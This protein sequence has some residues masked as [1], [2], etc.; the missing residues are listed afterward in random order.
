[1]RD[2]KG[3]GL[4]R[5]LANKTLLYAVKLENDLPLKTKGLSCLVIYFIIICRQ[6]GHYATERADTAEKNE[7]K[8]D[9]THSSSS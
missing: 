7:R 4:I 6:R 9:R 8:V 2:K 3:S 1:M 5:Y